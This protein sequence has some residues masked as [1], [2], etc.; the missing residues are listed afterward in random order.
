MK[1]ERIYKF[2]VMILILFS[3]FVKLHVPA[4][5]PPQAFSLPFTAHTLQNRDIISVLG[6]VVLTFEISIEQL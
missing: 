3:L 2:L 4:E 1:F 6:A 5:M